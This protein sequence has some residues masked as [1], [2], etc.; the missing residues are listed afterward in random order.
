MSS[1]ETLMPEVGRSVRR[2][3]IA[4]RNRVRRSIHDVAVLDVD[5]GAYRF[6]YLAEVAASVDGFRPFIGFPDINRVYE[7]T[8]LWP[9]FDLR[10]MDRKRPDYPQYLRWLGLPPDADR[11]DVLSR[12]G[13]EQKGD[14]VS[15]AEAPHIG[16]DGA[17][18]TTFLVRGSSYAV[19]A[20]HSTAAANQR[21]CCTDR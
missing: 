15:L 10:V 14:T 17:T 4:W 9:F 2:F 12:S 21:V 1:A 20:H 18:Q 5:A 13:G 6:Q 16:V 7:S 19:R 11:I 8:R 3:G